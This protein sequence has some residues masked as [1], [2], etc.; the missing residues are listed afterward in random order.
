MK[1]VPFYSD[2]TFPSWLSTGGRFLSF[3]FK[4]L[5]IFSQD[6]K[7]M[8]KSNYSYTTKVESLVALTSCVQT[9]SHM[10]NSVKLITRYLNSC[11]KMNK[12]YTS[13]IQNCD[14]L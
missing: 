8:M 5:F 9:M 2:C 1:T 10:E 14:E 12:V 7:E 13:F 4:T 6:G 3:D 11:I